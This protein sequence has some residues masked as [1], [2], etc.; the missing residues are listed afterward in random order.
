MCHLEVPLDFLNS[1]RVRRLC[2]L[3]SYTQEMFLL[4]YIILETTMIY[5]LKSVTVIWPPNEKQPNIL[6]RLRS[7]LPALVKDIIVLLAPSSQLFGGRALQV[8]VP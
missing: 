8:E 1:L 4:G 6:S 5:L 2:L 7:L 3:V